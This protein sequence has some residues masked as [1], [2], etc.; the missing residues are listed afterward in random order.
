MTFHLDIENIGG[1]R[2]GTASIEQGVNAVQANNW[3]GK[4]SLIR[5]IE[6]AMGTATP[7]TEGT[8]RGRVELDTPEETV[9]A[10]LQRERGDAT[11]RGDVYLA[12][13]QDR[14]C[15][16]LFAF[17]DED[18]AVRE[19][20][21]RGD[22]LEAVLT[23]P[24]DLERIDERIAD[25]RAE[26]D[27][28]DTQLERARE[29][30]EAL[31]DAQERVTQLESELAD[32]EAEREELA[33]DAGANRTDELSDARAER[34]R[35]ADRIEQLETTIENIEGRLDERREEL[36]GLEPPEDTDVESRLAD[37]REKLNDAES[38][39]E[40]L[41]SVYT[42]NRRVL[43]EGRLD[44]LAEV[45]RGIDADGVTCWVC[46]H[47]GDRSELEAQ[48]DE[49]EA[50]IETRRERA[51]EHRARIDELETE[52]DEIREQRR[53]KQNLESEI[54][55]LEST[56]ADRQESLRTA[57]EQHAKLDERVEKLAAAVDEADERRTDVESER[58]YTRAELE[59][60]RERLETLESRADERDRLESERAE[61]AD[62]IETLRT[63]K[64]RVKREIREAF[65]EAMADVVDELD[66]GFESA[67]LTPSFD[68][69]VA[70]DGREASLDA[71]SEGEIELL[72][73]V[74][75]LA[76]H[77][78][79]GVDERVPVVL[80]DGVGGLSGENLGTL[81]EFLR[82]RAPYLVTTAYPEQDTFQGHSVDPAEWA[83][84][85]DTVA[86]H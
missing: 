55:D 38:E 20:V 8:D 2:S 32:L 43:D 85:G 45:D 16:D 83:V 7:L 79:F 44:L 31:P 4:S 9:V 26:R 61:L 48:L 64:E 13:E 30:A 66:P 72:G 28:V 59:D 70:R 65:D 75:A 82:G 21:R 74:A 86:A 39:I 5:A 47:E 51:S 58:K 62:E 25:L 46:G 80:L 73:I 22:D 27:R 71:L 33:A 34:D 36:E 84:V 1:I 6:T 3:Q 56:L 19:A 10:E 24:L 11:R 53:R 14:V 81:V 76:G 78:T 52:R 54:A 17:L 15:A 42:A 23:R 69:V 77:E 12:D 18:N 57:R 68:L 40:L 50:R 37:A 63:R 60:A 29:A 49:L 35:L 67:R 41:R